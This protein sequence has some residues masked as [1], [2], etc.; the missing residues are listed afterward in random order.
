MDAEAKHTSVPSIEQRGLTI[1]DA[2]AGSGKT[3]RNIDSLAEAAF[4]WSMA[5]ECM[6]A[7]TFNKEMAEELEDRLAKK[8]L[9]GV[10][11]STV[12]AFCLGLVTEDPQRFGF[13][14]KPDVLDREDRYLQR[15]CRQYFGS[16]PRFA[17]GWWSKPSTRVMSREPGF[18][19]FCA[20]R[21][22]ATPRSTR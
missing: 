9:D 6:L 19:T 3:T 14:S 22:S 13:T 7:L 17:P 8:D 12:H 11:A 15:Q 10:N 18:G 1:I 16:S 21:R 2:N 20:T 5:P 4:E